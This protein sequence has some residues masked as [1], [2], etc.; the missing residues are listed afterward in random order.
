MPEC[1]KCNKQF[2]TRI[3]IENKAR[4]LCNRVYC[5]ECSPF[6]EHNNRKLHSRLDQECI[7]K[8]CGRV[9]I[10]KRNKGHTKDRCNACGTHNR[11]RLIKE[12]AVNLKGGSCQI[13]GYNRCLRALT[14]H[15]INEAEKSFQISGNTNKSWARIEE[16]LKKCI[17]LCHNCHDEYHS[18]II[19]I[20][21]V[22]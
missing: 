1:K 18:G 22:R 17:L 8:E 14:F 2:S 4:N 12:R 15:H 10:Y 20:S 5:L 16:E 11:N 19:E 6:D 9:Y 13:C 7:C 3:V 21:N